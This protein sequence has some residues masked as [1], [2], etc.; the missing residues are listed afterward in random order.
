MKLCK[1]RYSATTS[2][3]IKTLL[4]KKYTLPYMVIAALVQH[5][6]SF[7]KMAGP[8][9]VVW[10][11]VCEGFP[12]HIRSMLPNLSRACRFLHDLL[13]R[14]AVSMLISCWLFAHAVA[15]S[16]CAA[17]QAGHQAITERGAQAIVERALPLCDHTRSA[18][19]AVLSWSSG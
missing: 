1:L 4:M 19:R 14:P 18:T 11:Q 15:A 2:V 3:F 8:L 5:F 10:H 17:I 6:A 7:E 12:I 9:P 13:L 16:L